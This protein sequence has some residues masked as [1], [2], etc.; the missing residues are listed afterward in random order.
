PPVS[1]VVDLGCGPGESTVLL[2]EV[3]R[4]AVLTGLDASPAHVERARRRVPRASFAVHDVTA[5]LPVRGADLLYARLVLAHLP[6]PLTVVAGWRRQV[7]PEGIVVIEDLEA[8]EA[9]A[10]VLRDYD[11]LSATVVGAGGGPMY[12]GREL[13]PLG[14]RLVD[15]TVDAAVAARIYRVNV[16]AWRADPAFDA[17]TLDAL[18]AGLDRLVDGEPSPPVT[19]VVR[20]LVLCGAKGSDGSAEPSEQRQSALRPPR[21]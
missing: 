17:G 18:A 8:I 16:A 21:R 9:P 15:V 5:P 12:A 7:G 14:G 1:H 20:Q 3:C 13:A 19:W 4:P 6:D 11:A 10:G 2:A